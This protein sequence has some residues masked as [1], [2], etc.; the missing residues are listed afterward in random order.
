LAVL[1]ILLRMPPLRLPSRE[2]GSVDWL[3]ALALTAGVVPLLL[4]LSFG[5]AAGDQRGN[6]WPW[7]SWQ[8]A[9]LVVAS[10]VGTALFLMVERRSA[11]PIVDLSL[12][13]I[14]PFR[15]TALA[16]FVVG[17]SF[18]AAIVF[19]PLFMVNVV[20]LSATRS[21]LTTTPLTMGLIAGNIAV[22]QMVARLGKYK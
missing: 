16:A 14:R 6:G 19:L 17:G 12:F 15:L 5:R 2:G 21:G 8:I 3:G 13:G 10:A 7:L 22:G 11:N 9:S 4:A 18:L 1:F 20:G